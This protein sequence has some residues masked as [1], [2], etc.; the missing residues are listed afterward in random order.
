M[1]IEVG[2]S[3][4]IEDDTHLGVYRSSEWAERCFCTKC[5]TSLFYRLVG[6]NYDVIWLK[7]STTPT[8]ACRW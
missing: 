8:A 6:K 3:L 5:G 2:S 1:A 4:K 7:R